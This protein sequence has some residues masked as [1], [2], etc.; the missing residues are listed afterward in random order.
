MFNSKSSK[1]APAS[2]KNELV[3]KARLEREARQA[4][5]Q[6]NM[7]AITIQV[8]K[9]WVSAGLLHIMCPSFMI[10]ASCKKLDWEEEGVCRVKVG[11][12]SCS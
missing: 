2:G 5:K 4:E 3:E 12:K 11:S 1:G 10:I 7:G 8:I 6:R 9:I